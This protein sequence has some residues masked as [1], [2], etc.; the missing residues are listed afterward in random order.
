MIQYYLGT[1]ALEKNRWTTREPSYQV[2]EILPW[3][4]QDDYTGIELW[5]YHF[6]KADAAE[7]ARLITA[8]T[9]C[10]YNSYATFS[11]GFTVAHAQLVADVWALGACAVKFNFSNDL[12][13][14]QTEVQTLQ[15]IA[16]RL[17]KHVKMLCECHPGTIMENP[18]TAAEVLAQFD[19]Q[20]GAI[21]HLEPVKASNQ[22]CF[23]AYADRIVHLHVQMRAN[24]NDNERC[25][26]R[27]HA[28]DA[29]ARLQELQSLG[30]SGNVTIEFTRDGKTVFDTYQNATEDF[31]FVKDILGQ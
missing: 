6:T 20:F 23:A 9:P 19:E 14:M 17:P 15:E 18:Q 4:Q 5:E 1:A 25:M 12:Q 22:S 28:Q 31:W 10:I 21:V 7:H 8:Q 26:L 16:S 3:V 29:K 30:F 27:E 24:P 11:D 2:S 13:T